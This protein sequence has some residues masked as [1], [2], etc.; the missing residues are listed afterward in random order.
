MP[1]GLHFIKEVYTRSRDSLQGD[2]KMRRKKTNTIVLRA[3]YFVLG[4]A[5]GMLAITDYSKEN[6]S[7]LSQALELSAQT[8]SP[9]MPNS[10]DLP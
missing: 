7:I 3:F 6:E 8:F 9:I 4:S 1:E 2:N 10:T 5:V